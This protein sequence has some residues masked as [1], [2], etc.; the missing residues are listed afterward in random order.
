M[1]ISDLLCQNITVDVRIRRQLL[2]EF[3]V[4]AADGLSL[5]VDRSP[6]R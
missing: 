5:R 2:Q 1:K 3:A 4:R 6:Y